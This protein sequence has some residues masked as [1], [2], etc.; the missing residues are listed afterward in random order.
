MTI[1]TTIQRIES[2]LPDAT[3]LIAVT[4]TKPVAL[5]QEAY[6]AGCRRFG[7]N[8]VQE[9]VDKQPQLPADLEWHLIG[10]LQTNK[11]KYI[12]PFVSLIHSVDSLK[13]L[14]EINKQA[15]RH[16]RVIAC[17]LQIH[18]AQE[19]TKFGFDE[20]EA[21]TLLNSPELEPLSNIRIVG[22]MGM[23]TNTDDETQIRQEFRSLKQLYDRLSRIQRSNVQFQEL[24]MG[25][26]SDYLLA[27]EEGST[28]VRVG[29]AIFGTRN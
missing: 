16:H 27:I 14:Q 21:E 26:S 6:D 7:E 15:A 5:L 12:A 22:L 13:V 18:I 28:M 1:S 20:T 11:V 8:K 2:Q 3:K 25:M 4:K 19:E 24:S 9:M 23:A 17:L 10:H 29:S